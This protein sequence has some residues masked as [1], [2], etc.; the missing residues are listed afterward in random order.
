MASLAK[1]IDYCPMFFPTLK[2]IDCQVGK[3][4]PAKPTT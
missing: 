2:V 3:F 1:Q 4:T